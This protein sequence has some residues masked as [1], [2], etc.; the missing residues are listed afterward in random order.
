MRTQHDAQRATYLQQLDTVQAQGD[1]GMRADRATQREREQAVRADAAART[2]SIQAD[3]RARDQ[4][5]RARHDAEAIALQASASELVVT[6]AQQGEQRAEQ[7]LV[8]AEHTAVQRK[9]ART[10]GARATLDRGR[11]RAAEILSAVALPCDGGYEARA[12]ARGGVLLRQ[13]DPG[14]DEDDRA[15]SV[16]AGGRTPEQQQAAEDEARNRAQGALDGAVVEAQESLDALVAEVDQLL[17]QA[18]TLSDAE[19]A[20]VQAVI[21]ARLAEI[22]VMQEELA[23]R[24]GASGDADAA[25]AVMQINM[26][27]VQAMGQVLALATA[28]G[29]DSQLLLTRI[30][31]GYQNAIVSHQQNSMYYIFVP[32][33]RLDSDDILGGQYPNLPFS[34]LGGELLNG[35]YP[36]SPT[37]VSY[38]QGTDPAT[39]D[40]GN[41]LSAYM[42][43]LAMLDPDAEFVLGGHSSSGRAVADAAID[44]LD[45]HGDDGNRIRELL[46]FDPHIIY[47]SGSGPS[48]AFDSAS[49]A[50]IAANMEISIF[51]A[52][53]G[54]T[55]YSYDGNQ[56]ILPYPEEWETSP[57][58]NLRALPIPDDTTAALRHYWIVGNMGE[59]AAA[60]A[61]SATNRRERSQVAPATATPDTGTA[62]PIASTPSPTAGPV[63][64]PNVAGDSGTGTVVIVDTSGTDSLAMRSEPPYGSELLRIPEGA[65][66]TITGRTTVPLGEGV[67]VEVVWYRVEYGGQTGWVHSQYIDR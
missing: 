26:N 22:R 25:A 37:Q 24:I 11:L 27:M 53:V 45:R 20:T 31:T 47:P 54:E 41:D 48:R 17:S 10:E 13:G 3:W 38:F 49:A 52:Q 64:W 66:V 33:A 6:R 50:R 32:A 12:L 40:W 39:W 34:E 58:Q 46:L 23:Q 18:Q 4:R 65:E 60:A 9:A 29:A 14:W 21:E 36:I 19:L 16:P 44:Q 35:T 2:A 57:D 8:S 43:T 42:D 63:Y 5:S 7:H 30:Q 59:G 15:R 61:T 1:E 55:T 56:S 67:S 51:Q 62:P 28:H